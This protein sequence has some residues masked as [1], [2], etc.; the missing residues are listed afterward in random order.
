MTQ[1]LI[2]QRIKRTCEGCGQVKEWELVEAP[3]ADIV[4]MSEWCTAIREIPHEGK[5]IKLVVQACSLACVNKAAEK[6]Y[7]QPE[8]PADDINLASLRAQSIN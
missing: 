8:E 5:F 6:L 7:V 3:D 1:E 4:S 2:S